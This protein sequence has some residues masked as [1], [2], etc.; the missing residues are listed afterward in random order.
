MKT[1]REQKEELRNQR[2]SSYEERQKK[3]KKKARRDNLRALGTT[4]PIYVTRPTSSGTVASYSMS[5]WMTLLAILAI[6]LNVILWGTV[7]VIKAV[8]VLI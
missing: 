2:I 3:A 8:E 4:A 7:G 5:L 1:R 6:F